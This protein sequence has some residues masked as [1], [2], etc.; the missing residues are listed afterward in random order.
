MLS[1]SIQPDVG[2]EETSDRANGRSCQTVDGKEEKGGEG[3]GK[4]EEY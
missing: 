1:V 4:R 3:E 2:E